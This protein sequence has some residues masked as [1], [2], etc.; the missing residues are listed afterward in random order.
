MQINYPPS[1]Q[2]IPTSATKV[3]QGKLFQVWQWEQKLFDGSTKTFE[4]ILRPATVM[5]LP[6]TQ[7][8]K[9]ILT[10]QEQPGE[11]KFIGLIGGIIDSGEELLDA[12][13]RELLEE[14][15]YSAKN[16]ILWDAVQLINKIEWPVYTFI[17]KGLEKT[18]KAE[19]DA[20]E[21]IKLMEVTFD[22]FLNLTHQNNFRD[23]EVVMKIHKI[24]LNPEEM[25]ATKKLLLS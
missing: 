6:V 15:G 24:E 12:V 23:I 13:K 17:A 2:P 14:S 19:P 7:E 16:F 3:F 18:H 4:K 5:V 22:E 11:G 9:I 20:G 8:G 1:K 10:E 25:A 21:K